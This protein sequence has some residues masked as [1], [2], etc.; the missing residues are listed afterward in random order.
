MKYSLQL[1]MKGE[2]LEIRR[3]TEKSR[4]TSWQI[5]T[6]AGYAAPVLAAWCDF[7]RR[8]CFFDPISGECCESL[9]ADLA[10]AHPDKLE[11]VH[12]N[13]FHGGSARWYYHKE[14]A[15]AASHTAFAQVEALAILPPQAK[16]FRS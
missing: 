12:I 11:K 14:V 8:E 15:D 6:P 10:L 4:I 1:L 5:R 9:E 13:L 16:G 3:G 2:P 7:K